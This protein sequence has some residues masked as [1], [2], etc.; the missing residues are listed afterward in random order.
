MQSTS[1]ALVKPCGAVCITGACKALRCSM[2]HRRFVTMAHLSLR[3]ASFGKVTDIF[4]YFKVCL[5]VDGLSAIICV[6]NA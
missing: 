1:Q 3:T 2:H 5:Y 4:V 6:N